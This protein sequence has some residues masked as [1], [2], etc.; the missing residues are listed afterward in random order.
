M[1]ELVRLGVAMRP[2]VLRTSSCE[3]VALVSPRPTASSFFEMEPDRGFV[4]EIRE[5]VARGEPHRRA[6]ARA[7]VAE[8]IARL[9]LYAVAE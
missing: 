4:D 2:G 7:A 9:G 8:A 1:L 3:D 6:R 5:R